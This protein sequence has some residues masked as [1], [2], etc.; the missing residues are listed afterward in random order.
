MEATEQTEVKKRRRRERGQS[1]VEFAMIAPLLVILIFGF[2]D[3][4][5]LY[6]AWVTIQG[7]AREGARFGVTGRDT[8]PVA[9]SNRVACIKYWAAQRTKSLTNS[10]TL[11]S[12]TVR[13]WDYPDYANPPLEGNA[14]GP[15][16]ALEVKVEYDFEP[17]TPLAE[18]LLGFVHITGKERMVNEPFG[19]C[20][21]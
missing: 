13:R 5:R 7:A 17:S 19:T 11:I 9:T 10:S 6:Q 20:D 3:T 8:C 16:D 21:P 4:A 2:V 14:G 18:T 12:V 15:C 1:L